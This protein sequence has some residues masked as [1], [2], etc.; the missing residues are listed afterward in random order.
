LCNLYCLC[1]KHHFYIKHL[2]SSLQPF[3]WK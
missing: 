1:N 3:S 2:M